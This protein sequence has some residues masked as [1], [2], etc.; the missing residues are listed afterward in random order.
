MIP[1][2]SAAAPHSIA[3][4]AGA[5]KEVAMKVP[6]ISRALA[7]AALA[8]AFA[9]AGAAA[10]AAPPV[11]SPAP[12]AVEA[13]GPL[14]KGGPPPHAPAHGYRAKHQ[15]RYYPG[16]SV[17]YDAGRR[18]WFYMQAGGWTIGASL[19]TGLKAQLGE[20]VQIGMD[21]DKPYLR[22]DEHAAQYPAEKYKKK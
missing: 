4:T 18:L 6:S 19:P 10:D 13:V 8:A 12:A 3:A 20:Y 7:A 9:W 11:P 1:I 17:Y 15:Y 16:C 22:H 21:E 2:Q 5:S 14:A